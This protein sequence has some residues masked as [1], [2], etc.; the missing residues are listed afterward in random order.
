MRAN[1][2]HSILSLLWASLPG[3]FD[4]PA[5]GL[6]RRPR[7]IQILGADLVARA[8][9]PGARVPVVG[10]HGHDSR[11]RH[12]PFEEAPRVL[13]AEPVVAR[14]VAPMVVAGA[15]RTRNQ[16]G[17]LVRVQLGVDGAIVE[18]AKP[19]DVVEVV[20]RANKGGRQERASG[21]KIPSCDLVGFPSMAWVPSQTGSGPRTRIRSWCP[22]A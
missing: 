9:A 10:R 7:R 18:L 4:S 8:S 13:G 16:N 15:E 2:I 3:V 11:V 22:A 12:G 21:Y 19:R 6:P 5:D 17:R 1:S 20:C 14:D